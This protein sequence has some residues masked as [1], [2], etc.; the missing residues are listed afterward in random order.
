MG[1]IKEALR[2]FHRSGPEDC[3]GLLVGDH[4]MYGEMA[5]GSYCQ[6]P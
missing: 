4:K 3:A 6:S 1:V 5:W 2:T